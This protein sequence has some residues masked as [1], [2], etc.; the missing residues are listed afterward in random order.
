MFNFQTASE[1]EQEELCDDDL[2]RRGG[3]GR[4]RKEEGRSPWEIRSHS[5]PV[6]PPVCYEINTEHCLSVV[7]SSTLLVC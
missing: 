1:G 4:E 6:S 7:L 5:S 2:Q 3:E